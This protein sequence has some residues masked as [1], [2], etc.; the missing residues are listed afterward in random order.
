MFIMSKTTT[1]TN[2]CHKQR[3]LEYNLLAECE[4][5]Y[6]GGKLPLFGEISLDFQVRKFIRNVSKFVPD[7]TVLYPRRQ[8]TAKPPIFI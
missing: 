2:V 7:Y 4:T 5:M 1:Y 6:S 8:F 3:R